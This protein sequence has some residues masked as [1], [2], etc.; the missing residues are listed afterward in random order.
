[1]V[2]AIRWMAA[3]VGGLSLASCDEKPSAYDLA[4][5]PGANLP[6]P[7]VTS[8]NAQGKGLAKGRV[9]TNSFRAWHYRPN[10]VLPLQNLM[11]AVYDS[12]LKPPIPTEIV[13]VVASRIGCKF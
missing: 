1:M 11:S 4:D 13:V 6:L 2:R 12:T 3:V 9:A 10:A 8:D 7:V 5:V